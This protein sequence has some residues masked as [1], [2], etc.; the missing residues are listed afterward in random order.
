[1]R[2][3]PVSSQGAH[4]LLCYASL[5]KDIKTEASLRESLKKIALPLPSIDAYSRIS[6]G[7]SLHVP[8]KSSKGVAYGYGRQ[9]LGST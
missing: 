5:S 8:M 7:I 6:C 3:V 9:T 2:V 4:L 1:M